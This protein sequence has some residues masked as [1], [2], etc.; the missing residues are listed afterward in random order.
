VSSFQKSLLRVVWISLI[1]CGLVT[2]IYLYNIYYINIY[3]YIICWKVR[4]YQAIFHAI[5]FF[6]AFFSDRKYSEKVTSNTHIDIPG[7]ITVNLHKGDDVLR[8][9]EEERNI[10]HAIQRKSV[11]IGHFLRRNCFLN[12]VI[13]GKREGTRVRGRRR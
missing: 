8:R 2:L 11:W 4:I 9:D 6:S 1:F 12:H 7:K 13:E 10:L 5:L 3:I